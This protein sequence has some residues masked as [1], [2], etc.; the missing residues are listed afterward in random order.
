MSQIKKRVRAGSKYLS[1]KLSSYLVSRQP[2]LSR[3][4]ASQMSQLSRTMKM[5]ILKRTSKKFIISRAEEARLLIREHQIY[6]LTILTWK[7]LLSYFT[8]QED[9]LNYSLKK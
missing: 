2:H 7:T 8:R 4:S 3:L 6:Q 1:K 5:G 9:N